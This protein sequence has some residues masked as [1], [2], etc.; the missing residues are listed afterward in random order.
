MANKSPI[1]PES[2]EGKKYNRVVQDPRVALFKMYYTDI[3]SDTFCNIRG[4]AIKAGYTES[5]AENISNNKPKWWVEFIESGE[6][7]RAEML[8]LSERNMKRVLS[9]SPVDK[10]QEKLQIQVSQFI[11]ERVGKDFY[12]TRKE[13][14]D[15]GGRRL[16]SNETRENVKIDVSTLFKGVQSPS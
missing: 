8:D 1:L 4:S 16:F 10:E 12:S 14:T 11:S 9:V 5:Y 2:N 6:K 3:K 7:R 13:L 15:A